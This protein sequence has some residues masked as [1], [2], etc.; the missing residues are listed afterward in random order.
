MAK[1]EYMDAAD[2]STRSV[3]RTVSESQAR[4]YRRSAT[5]SVYRPPQ[6]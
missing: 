4:D 3:K 2:A 6:E 1:Y 5:F